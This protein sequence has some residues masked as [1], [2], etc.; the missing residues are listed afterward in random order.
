[1]S[2]W[3]KISRELSQISTIEYL[4]ALEQAASKAKLPLK[5]LPQNAVACRIN[6]VN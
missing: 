6:F 2:H 3:G 5:D 4:S 1:M